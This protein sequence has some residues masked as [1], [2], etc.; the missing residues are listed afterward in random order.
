MTEKEIEIAINEYQKGR[1]TLGEAVLLAKI[2][3]WSF[4]D[5]LHERKIA[6]NIDENDHIKEIEKIKQGDYKDFL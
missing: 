5:I 2:D 3:Y 4:L 1:V 6:A